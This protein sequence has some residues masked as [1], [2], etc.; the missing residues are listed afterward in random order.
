MFGLVGGKREYII[1]DAKDTDYGSIA[2]LHGQNFAR[3]W[4]KTEILTLSSQSNCTLLV[5]R[6]VGQPDE[7]IA[8]FN[9]MRGTQEEAEILS[10]AVDTRTRRQGLGESLLREGILRLRADRVEKLLL[11]VDESNVSAVALYQKLG[12][13]IVGNRPGYYHSSGSI[14]RKGTALVMSLG[15]E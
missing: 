7:P 13:L 11:E 5:A 14:E 15:L 9:I 3:G 2:A 4:T 6:P 1:L 12:F 10:I 8:G